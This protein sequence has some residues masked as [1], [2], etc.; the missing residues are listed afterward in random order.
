VT[1]TLKCSEAITSLKTF[2]ISTSEDSLVLASP[3]VL[4]PAS[5]WIDKATANPAT[6][7]VPG[8]PKKFAMNLS[9]TQVLEKSCL[10]EMH[11]AMFLT[12]LLINFSRLLLVTL[13]MIIETRSNSTL[14]SAALLA[15][16]DEN[17]FS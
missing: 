10:Q 14:L 17:L 7:S 11:S 8:R 2:T 6:K 3:N 5:S 16:N 9:T 12:T 4:S 1:A 15:R 13:T